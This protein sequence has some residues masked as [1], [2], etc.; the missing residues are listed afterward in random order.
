MNQNING[1][2]II[3]VD[4]SG[5]LIYATQMDAVA[6]FAFSPDVF[7]DLEFINKEAFIS[8]VGALFQAQNIQPCKILIVLSQ[9][10][11]FEKEFKSPM[12]AE[13]EKDMQLFL[14]NVPFEHASSIIFENDE[15]KIIATNKDIYQVIAK[16]FEMQHCIVEY[17]IP[18][19]IFPIDINRMLSM[20]QQELITTYRRAQSFKQYSFLTDISLQRQGAKKQNVQSNQ[21]ERSNDKQAGKKVKNRSLFILIGVFILLLMILGVVIALTMSPGK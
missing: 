16:A 9:N 19:F 13:Q 7:L 15:S 20:S 4:V 11:L 1:F 3:Y 12:T 2:G 21:P 17:I 6:Q 10:L 18:A 5:M 8:Q 14:D